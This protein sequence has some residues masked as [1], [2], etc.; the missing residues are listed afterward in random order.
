M[1]LTIKP[2]LVSFD[3]TRFLLHVQVDY[4]RLSNSNASDVINPQKVLSDGVVF[5][6]SFY[7]RDDHLREDH[8]TSPP[9]E[10]TSS[11]L[12]K[13]GAKKLLEV[14]IYYVH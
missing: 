2:R 8:G 3:V 14:E 4:L 9:S 13:S 11:G 5:I 10:E 12:E 1:W 6:T 7:Y